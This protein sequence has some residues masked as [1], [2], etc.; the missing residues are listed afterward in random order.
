M[1]GLMNVDLVLAEKAALGWKVLSLVFF[2]VGVDWSCLPEFDDLADGQCL[3]QCQQHKK[4][5]K[6]WGHNL[7]VTLRSVWVELGSPKPVV[8][9]VWW[10]HPLLVQ[11]KETFD[12]NN[13]NNKCVILILI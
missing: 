9:R 13:N 5:P 7:K 11:N 4:K 8:F 10:L 12:V 6:V 3:E 1:A 2:G